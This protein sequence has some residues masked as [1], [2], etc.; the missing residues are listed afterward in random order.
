MARTKRDLSE[1]IIIHMT[2]L[3][4]DCRD[5]CLDCL[6][7]GIKQDTLT[8]LWNSPL[9]M[10]TLFPDHLLA[11][12]EEDISHHEEKHSSSQKKPG[13]YHPYSQS[14]QQKQSRGRNYKWKLLCC[15]WRQEEL[16][17]C[18]RK[19]RHFKLLEFKFGWTEGLCLWPARERNWILYL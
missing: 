9:H 14:Y 3:I 12:A 1:D 16:C 6:K 7:A 8:A 4:L 5:S 2:N 11:K 10:V 15:K 18:D 13:C 17:I 19:A